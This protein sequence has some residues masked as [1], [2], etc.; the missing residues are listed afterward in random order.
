[1]TWGK[2]GIH[3]LWISSLGKEMDD[4]NPRYRASWGLS[5]ND[6]PHILIPHSLGNEHPLGPG[7]WFTGTAAA[8]QRP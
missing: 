6:I 5:V 7:H 3:G 2:R 1:M 8:G 4:L